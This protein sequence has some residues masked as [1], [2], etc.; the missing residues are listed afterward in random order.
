[1]TI[2]EIIEI[3]AA[4]V[5]VVLTIAVIHFTF[6]NRKKTKAD[7]IKLLWDRI[8]ALETKLENEIQKRDGLIETLK[9]RIGQLETRLRDYGVPLPRDDDE[10]QPLKPVHGLGMK[11]R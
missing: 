8:D 9:R 5:G 1:M 4:I 3:I 11:Q 7:N 10:T 6:T 2:K